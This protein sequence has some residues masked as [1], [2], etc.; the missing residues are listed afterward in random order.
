[1]DLEA[2]IS[3]DQHFALWAVLLAVAAFGFWIDASRVGRQLSGAAMALALSM[4]LSNINLIP[5]S[6]MA[7][8]IVW[9][10]LVPLAIP[11]LLFKADIRRI[12]PETRGL[13]AAFV[14]GA[15]GTVLGAL[16]GIALLPLGE[17]AHSLAGAFAA[18][19][20]GGSMNFAAVAQIQS[21]DSALIGASVAADNVVGVVYMALLAAMP[22]LGLLKK[23]LPS[24]IIEQAEL[25]RDSVIE[26][27]QET[28]GLNLLHISVAFA[29]A[30][31]ICAISTWLSALLEI[32]AYRILVIT[33]LAVLVAN[34]WPRQMAKL[35]GDYEL[36]LLLMY[37]FF[38]VVGA[39]ADVMAMLNSSLEIVLFVGIIVVSHM[40]TIFT[41]SRLFK[42][43]L[44]EVIIASSACA[45]GP[46]A[47]AALAAGKRWQALVVPAVM[48]GVFGY[49][50]ANFIGV[51]LANYLE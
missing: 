15:I 9:S 21:M 36:G 2:L 51:G 22:A 45:L 40:L 17:E 44:A 49:V 34:V 31:S 50:V 46:A 27:T 23:W 4:L 35:E 20:I 24:P 41:L 10:Y 33:A 47:A 5:A 7:Y 38:A 8:D 13:L 12:I 26:H 39:G 19:Y 1:M 14:V 16:I 6:A 48:L 42:L 3:P 25:Q 43:D 32:T 18:S 30:L 11:L 37:V 29:L 28:T